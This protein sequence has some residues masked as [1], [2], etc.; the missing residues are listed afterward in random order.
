MDA[1]KT[2]E[3]LLE[4]VYKRKRTPHNIKVKA[5]MLWMSGWG[6]RDIAVELGVSHETVRRWT[7]KIS[8]VTSLIKAPKR[9]RKYVA[10]DDSK[11]LTK[12]G[13]FYIWAAR[14]HETKE[15]L[16]LRVTRKRTSRMASEFIFKVLEVCEGEPLFIVDRGPWFCEPLRRLGFEYVNERRGRRNIVER[17]FASLKRRIR[18][19]LGQ[20]SFWG[21]GVFLAL[22]TF[23]YN[24]VKYH[25]GIRGVLCRMEG[26]I[27]NA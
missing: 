26:V 25:Q 22:F 16:A 4:E 24:F 20:V 27:K 3:E 11:V 1:L 15:I 8:Y 17:T 18:L 10:I 21:L 2:L 7:R 12:S 13:V 9:E 23:W 14:D 6:L 19:F 5:F